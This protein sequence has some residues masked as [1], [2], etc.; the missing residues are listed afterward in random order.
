[1][2]VYLAAEAGRG[3][4]LVENRERLGNRRN[5]SERASGPRERG[6]AEMSDLDA[7]EMM[8]RVDDL[9][10]EEEELNGQVTALAAE[11]WTERRALEITLVE[12]EKE[13]D[14]E[15]SVETL[16]ETRV[17]RSTLDNF[18]D[19]LGKAA[20]VKE[21][22]E[23][24]AGLKRQAEK[25]TADREFLKSRILG[26]GATGAGLGA[27]PE[28]TT[29]AATVE[30][31]VAVKI[32]AIA[33]GRQLELAL[34][35]AFG[36]VSSARTDLTS[37]VMA[38]GA[39][40]VAE[41]KTVDLADGV[42]LQAIMA[43]MYSECVQADATATKR[44]GRGEDPFVFL[45]KFYDV[46]TEGGQQED[47]VKATKKELFSEVSAKETL[48]EVM[49]RYTRGAKALHVL[50]EGALVGD[51]HTGVATAVIKWL[52]RRLK[53]NFFDAYCTVELKRAEGGFRE[54]EPPRVS[55]IR[56]VLARDPK[57]KIPLQRTTRSAAAVG[58]EAPRLDGPRP[59]RPR[60]CPRCGK[61]DPDHT[62]Q[63][64]TFTGLP[65]CFVCDESGHKAFE[66]PNRTVRGKRAGVVSE[67]NSKPNTVLTGTKESVSCS[68]VQIRVKSLHHPR[69]PLAPS[70]PSPPSPSD[71]PR[72]RQGPTK[73][74]RVRRRAR[75]RTMRKQRRR[76]AKPTK[77][78]ET[79]DGGEA[80]PTPE[81]EGGRK[82]EMA[83]EAP[84]AI[85]AEEAVTSH[86]E[87]ERGDDQEALEA[88]VKQAEDGETPVDTE[89]HGAEH[90]R[91]LRRRERKVEK[92]R[93]KLER[94]VRKN[95]RRKLR[96]QF[97]AA[98]AV[99]TQK[100]E[101]AMFRDQAE[102]CEENKISGEQLLAA[103]AAQVKQ[104]PGV[105]TGEARTRKYLRGQRAFLTARLSSPSGEEK[106]E[107]GAA[108]RILEAETLGD[109]GSEVELMSDKVAAA[110]LERNPGLRLKRA[111]VNL[112]AVDGKPVET[113]GRMTVKVE[114]HD[115]EARAE[116]LVVHNLPYQ[117]VA[118]VSLLRS[119]S[120]DGEHIVVNLANGSIDFNLPEGG[121]SVEGRQVRRLGEVTAAVVSAVGSSEDLEEQEERE[122]HESAIVAARASRAKAVAAALQEQRFSKGQ[123]YAVK[124]IV[125]KP[126]SAMVVKV[127]VHGEVEVGTQ[128]L[129]G[130]PGRASPE[131]EADPHAI[132]EEFRDGG[133]EDRGEGAGEDVLEELRTRDDVDVPAML[134]RVQEDGWTYIQVMNSGETPRTIMPGMVLAEIQ[135]GEL[136]DRKSRRAAAKIVKRVAALSVE[137]LKRPLR[138]SAITPVT[139]GM[140]E[141]HVEGNDLLSE[142]QAEALLQLLKRWRDAGAIVG[143][144]H[145]RL[146][147]LKGTAHVIRTATERP[148]R[149]HHGRKAPAYEECE[150]QYVDEFLEDD[151]VEESTSSYRAP[152]VLTRKPG[153]GVRFC[154][155][156]RA[157]NEVSEWDA[158]PMPNIEA[159]LDALGGSGFIST[160][161]MNSGYH[162]IE[163]APEH[164][165]KT[166]FA[167][168]R[169]LFQFKRMP[170]GL[171]SA[172]ATF[173]RAMT[174]IL[175]AVGP[176]RC[177][178]YLDDVVIFSR[179]WDQHLKDLDA[180]FRALH[181]AGVTIKL[182][183][184]EFARNRMNFLGHTI[185]PGVGCTP[186]DEKIR[187][188]R[189]WMVPDGKAKLHSFLQTAGFN[190][191]Y[192]KNFAAVSNPLWEL[193]RK[194]SK[195][196]WT[197]EHMAAFVKLKMLLTSKPVL[198][199]PN[200]ELPFRI[201]TD[202]SR[203]GIGATLVN[204][205]P[206]GSERVV[207]Y[208]SW[209]LSRYEKKYGLPELEGLGIRKATDRW[210]PYVFGRHF[211]I[212]TDHFS[213]QFLQ[214]GGSTKNDRLER[215]AMWLQ[216]FDYTIVYQKGKHLGD[217]DGLSRSRPKDETRPGE[218][219]DSEDEGQGSGETVRLQ[220][221]PEWGVA[222]TTASEQ[223]PETEE[224]VFLEYLR[225]E[226]IQDEKLAEVRERCIVAQE[227]G[228]P[229]VKA[230]QGQ[231]R[232]VKQVFGREAKEGESM[233]LQWRFD[234]K[235]EWRYWLPPAMRDDVVRNAHDA[236]A[237]GHLGAKKTF[238]KLVRSYFWPGMREKVEKYVASCQEC[239]ARRK[240]TRKEGFLQPVRVDHVR[241]R[242][243][244]D[245]VKLPATPAGYR[246]V[247]VLV[248]HLSKYGVAVALKSKKATTVARAFVEEWIL[249]R[250]RPDSILSD[251]G[252]EFV[253]ALL[254][255][256]NRLFGIQHTK[257]APYRPQSDGLVE[258]RNRTLEQ[259]LSHY[260]RGDQTDWVEYLPYVMYAYNTAVHEATGYTPFF[261]EFGREEGP[262]ELASGPPE[263]VRGPHAEEWQRARREVLDR[264]KVA[265]T[266]QKA[267]ADAAVRNRA[268]Q[269]RAKAAYDEGRVPA[270]LKPG[271]W[272]MV[273]R[274]TIDR[275]DRLAT[276][277]LAKEGVLAQVVEAKGPPESGPFLVRFEERQDGASQ[278]AVHAL[279]NLRKVTD[280]LPG[281]LGR[282]ESTPTQLQGGIGAK[283]QEV[284]RILDVR[285]KGG[286]EQFLVRWKNWPKSHKEWV[287]DVSGCEELVE[288]FRARRQNSQQQRQQ[289]EQ[290]RPQRPRRENPQRQGPKERRKVKK[291]VQ[292]RCTKG[293]VQERQ[294][295]FDDG[296][297]E[298]RQQLRW[299]SAD[300]VTGFN[301]AERRWDSDR[302]GDRRRHRD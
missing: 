244:M 261:L 58:A 113:L 25:V 262:L 119:L 150:K 199:F 201:R 177:L 232:V 103:A 290:Q 10:T 14:E 236:V 46:V 62:K 252:G 291:I 167:T 11:I 34:K 170:F 214:R 126:R 203:D 3:A 275:N 224:G 242:V 43:R 22:E 106:Y 218:D 158:F 181:D 129:C 60:R 115:R 68:A 211:E 121:R 152:V 288:E 148:T 267:R 142:D 76:V 293:G 220:Q 48:M 176:E 182:E 212:F 168:A 263:K 110:M 104:L 206:D 55:D 42:M 63:D 102:W 279:A 146:G 180:V 209:A 37:A 273:R 95:E 240:K 57:S 246:Y 254:S 36:G 153:G 67:T 234:R 179:T 38:L 151:V 260:V 8:K 159:Y 100:K 256:V 19:E 66:C 285:R 155:D 231:A 20:K 32:Q 282:H 272:V 225:R 192:I 9:G 41:L 194:E 189:D 112:S 302:R 117:L 77:P 160:V 21:K 162:Q 166:A 190:R 33:A 286:R 26:K 208:A 250:G 245:L 71:A 216:Q 111:K 107:V 144:A 185:I 45:Q 277:K 15:V 108:A 278:S 287:D 264:M 140:L 187:A 266:L 120:A 2:F 276:P 61:K 269:D 64:C 268:Q 197:T 165:H 79:E 99:A 195:W 84:V 131:D 70:P 27:R 132:D 174:G 1:L 29:I 280:R 65:P 82:E 69:L 241:Q 228:H 136:A 12:K 271:D 39:I 105:E 141:K 226:Q 24:L 283:N 87:D 215:W 171:V 161:D 147:K 301:E 127:R 133:N 284:A 18:G 35:Q 173:Q 154:I 50:K 292:A 289:Q 85:Q 139:D 91:T 44:C 297:T 75:Q 149:T 186:Q 163:I 251:N 300:D 204:V 235:Q 49:E 184:C 172:P 128:V 135:A 217:V 72:E 83:E 23:R 30:A 59:E 88:T 40:E 169:G 98:A 5:G 74:A 248:D 4:S 233:V 294:V 109:I 92:R 86:P 90:N 134:V 205:L 89:Q 28:A 17:T 96:V 93:K 56:E 227:A 124:P 73:S 219:S 281:D 81:T 223:G 253:N 6:D 196:E 183:K 118:G 137:D 299:R 207:A 255:E 265:E 116:F 210:R 298:W 202:A 157:L 229:W 243:G 16:L 138:P 238:H 52:K 143:G 270:Q 114:A 51:E 200:F 257:T 249:K 296:T 237:A 97:R 193:T 221:S 274:P 47:V 101:D 247:L 175:Q 295:E 123:M 230:G 94:W 78:M 31:K 164:R 156:F 178:A 222:A 122:E 198:H 259:M 145:P 80:P 54:S 125:V 258:N 130:P 188:I 191:K 213:N 239:Q 53:D 7:D 13:G